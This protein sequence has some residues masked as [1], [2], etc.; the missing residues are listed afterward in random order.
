MQ[1]TAVLLGR[2]HRTIGWGDTLRTS[3]ACV[4]MRSWQRTRARTLS[5]KPQFA[6][7]LHSKGAVVAQGYLDE[8]AEVDRYCRATRLVTG[9]LQCTQPITLLRGTLSAKCFRPSLFT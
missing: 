9:L 4:L 6:T 5:Q 3:Q 8:L 1:Q 7:R 2:E